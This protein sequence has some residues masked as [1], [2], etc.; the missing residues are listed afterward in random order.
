MNLDFG[1]PLQRTKKEEKYPDKAVITMLAYQGKGTSRK[2]EFNTKA[3]EL[4]NLTS[5]ESNEV[6]LSFTEG[7][8][9][10]VNATGKDIDSYKMTKSS[11]K[12]FSNSRAYDYVAKFLGDL[13]VSIEREFNVNPVGD[14]AAYNDAPIC[15][16][17]MIEE[18][19][20]LDQI[21]EES[22]QQSENNEEPQEGVNNSIV[23]Q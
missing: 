7:K 13:D 12:S 10:V 4:L 19:K 17:E 14:G 20:I 2:F 23:N 9:F 22:I 18:E 5:E 15:R 11:P 3:C 16:M 21:V 6:A 8:I 1:V